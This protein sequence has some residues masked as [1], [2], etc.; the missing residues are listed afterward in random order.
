MTRRGIQH[1]MVHAIRMPWAA[2]ATPRRPNHETTRSLVRIQTECVWGTVGVR[3]QSV[4]H[5][6]LSTCIEH[7]RTPEVEPGS[8]AW[9]ACMMPLHYVRW[10]LC[11]NKQ[12]NR[13]ARCL[14][15]FAFSVISWSPGCSSS[16]TESSDSDTPYPD[17]MLEFHIGLSTDIPWEGTPDLVVT[18]FAP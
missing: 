8:Q 3:A 2:A 4:C 15:I 18:S 6:A 10:C 14:Y 7:M 11:S 12:L 5:P 1:Y 13:L 16:M 17:R 9:E